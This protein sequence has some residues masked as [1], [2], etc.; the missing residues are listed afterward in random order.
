MRQCVSQSV[1]WVGLGSVSHLHA[2]EA[3]HLSHPLAVTA[4]QVV[5]DRHHVH[6]FARQ[7]VEVGGQHSH[8]GLTLTWG[9]GSAG[10][11]REVSGVLRQR[12]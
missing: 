4:C 6:T 10:G 1:G 2:Q 11:G 3:R 12:E 8:K 7:R 9:G 5:I